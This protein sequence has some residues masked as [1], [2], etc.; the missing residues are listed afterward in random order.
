LSA[1]FIKA[2]FWLSA[3]AV[4]YAYLGYPLVITALARLVR[5]PVHVAPITP[6]VSLV[7]PA[8]NEGRVIAQKLDNSLALDYPRQQLEIIVISDGST[9]DTNQIVAAYAS[10]G[11]RLL[12][13]PPRRGKIAALNRAVPLTRGE[14][15][16][17]SDANAMLAPDTL[18]HLVRN[19]ADERVACVGGAKQ[20]QRDQATSA[21]GESAYWRY[22]SHLKRCD[23]A[24]GA[25]MGVAGELFAVRRERYVAVEQDSLIED[26]VLSLRLV[27]AGWRVVFEPMAVAWEQASPSL[28]AEWQRRTRIAA[29]GFQSIV[30]LVGMMNPLLGLPA[31]QYLSHR[32]LRWFAPLFMIAALLS[33]VALC[34][35]PF[36]RWI[37]AA[38][39]VFYLA[40][41]AGYFLARRGL[42]WRPLQMIFYFCFTNAAAL[43]GLY[44]Y[45]TRSQPVTWKKARD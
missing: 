19:F 45:L 25:A 10:R 44:R 43:V 39:I 35:L 20:V 41:I 7:I 26:F 16:V 34:S 22:E 38:Q 40:G 5:R 37:L 42:R 4:V 2:I 9:D 27:Q 30:R 23:S 17:F 1:G 18:R 8:Y 28:A 29:G 32:V 24:V 31:F 33:N 3:L 11:V 21:R 14:I 13:E 6:L 12:F 36:Y 15:I